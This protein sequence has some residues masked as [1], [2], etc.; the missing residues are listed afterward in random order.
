GLSEAVV[1]GSFMMDDF[2]M[3]G[4]TSLAE[5]NYLRLEAMELFERCLTEGQPHALQVFIEQQIS[6]EP[7]PLELLREI[8]D[9][10]HQR[11]IG[12]REYHT[13]V[14]DRVWRTITDDF[15]FQPTALIGG[16]PVREM[17]KLIHQIHTSRAP[18][19]DEEAVMLRKVLDTSLDTAAQ[20]REDIIM[21]EHLYGT[22][23]DW[24]N[25]FN[26]IV[27]RRFWADGRSDR[28]SGEAQ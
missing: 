17:E 18:L 19:T 27:G 7:P 25:A 21:T 12:L 23:S 8:A 4:L 15:G 10:L 14:L 26:A 2:G 28:Y 16:D 22:L 1:S 9:D 3:M 13:D 24:V 20:L 5:M 6:R 11:L